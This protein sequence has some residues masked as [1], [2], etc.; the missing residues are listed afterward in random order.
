MAVLSRI[1]RQGGL[2]HEG[3][4]FRSRKRNDE[5]LNTGIS[6]AMPSRHCARAGPGQDKLLMRPGSRRDLSRVRK[7]AKS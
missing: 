5:G 1:D 2:F 4:P 6:T 3:K 7:I